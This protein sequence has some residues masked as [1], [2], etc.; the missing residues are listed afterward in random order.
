M[1]KRCGCGLEYTED[2]FRCLPSPP[3]GGEQV[4]PW[5]EVSLVRNCLCESTL[6]W[7]PAAPAADLEQR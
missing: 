5:G 4:W 6:Y 1:T 7:E 2:T 3:A